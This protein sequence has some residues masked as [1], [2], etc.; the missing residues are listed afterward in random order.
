M[1]VVDFQA[2]AL[3]PEERHQAQM[4]SLLAHLKA[5]PV[6][7]IHGFATRWPLRVRQVCKREGREFT[8]TTQDI[9]DLAKRQDYR[10]AVSGLPFDTDLP[11][12]NLRNPFGPSIDRLDCAKGYTPDNIRIVCVIVNLALNSFG[13]EAL[14]KMC[15]A[16]CEQNPLSGDHP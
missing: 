6:A 8:V 3:T 4:L 15:R 12:H 7:N 10:C 9:M 2:H 5:D 1:T 11:G 14:L 13:D 16:V